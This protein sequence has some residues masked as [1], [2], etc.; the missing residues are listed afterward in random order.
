MTRT[1]LGISSD[2][3]IIS[4]VLPLSLG[5]TADCCTILSSTGKEIRPMDYIVLAL[6]VVADKDLYI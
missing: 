5:F 4:Y 1:L 6:G 2:F 3:S